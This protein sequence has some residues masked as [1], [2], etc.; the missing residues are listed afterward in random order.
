MA[1]NLPNGTSFMSRYKRISRKQLPGNIRVTR[2]RIIGPRKKPK[3]KK[4]VR[5]NLANTLTQDRAKRIRKKYRNLSRRQTGKGLASSL[6]NLGLNMGSKAINSVTGKKI[7]DKGIE[8][9]PNIFKYGIS[10]IKNINVQRA[11]ESDITDYI[12]EE[13]QNQTKNKLSNLFGGV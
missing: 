9:I 12:V 5:F 8:N 11:L 7:I 3:T 10:K 6:A 4:K 2:T 13:A 1:V